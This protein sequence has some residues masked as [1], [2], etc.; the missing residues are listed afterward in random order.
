MGITHKGLLQAESGI[1]QKEGIYFHSSSAFA[2]KNLFYGYWGA[3][4][5]CCAP[6]G[7]Y[8]EHFNAFLLF[9]IKSGV[10]HFSYRGQEFDAVCNDVVLLDCNCLHHYYTESEVEFYWFHFH[11]CASQAY[12]DLLWEQH[13]GHFP[14]MPALEQDFIRILEMFPLGPEADDRISYTIHHLLALLNQQGHKSCMI[15]PQIAQAKQFMETHFQEDL[16]NQDIAESVSLSP[17]YFAR[18]FRQE[19]GMSPHAYLAELRLTYA[20]KRLSESHDSVEQIALDC[21]FSSS[22][23]FIRSFKQKTGITP[24]KFRTLFDDLHLGKSSDD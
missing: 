11:G 22:A 16:S 13:K 19:T 14:Q 21:L 5:R 2:Q 17:F 9:F 1:L 12:C 7:V 23:N 20:K 18:R 8:R 24:H 4:Y 15:S 6:Y 10:M 3:F